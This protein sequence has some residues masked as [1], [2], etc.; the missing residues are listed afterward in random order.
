M[1][2]RAPW[3]F[4]TALALAGLMCLDTALPL[5]RAASAPR[6]QQPAAPAQQGARVERV[7]I[8]GNRRLRDEDVLYHIQ[9]RAGDPFS[10]E[11]VQRDLITLLNLP[12]FDKTETRVSTETGPLG[13]VI[14]IFTV[15]ELP[16]VRDVDFKGLKSV[17]E[18]DVLKAFR[19]QRVGVSKE[20]SLD[21]VKVN[22]ARRVIKELLAQSGHPN[23]VVNADVEEVSQTSVA[24]TFDINEG[25]RVRVVDIDFE[26]NKVFSDGELRGAMKYVKEAGLI[27]R[28]KGQDILHLEKLDADLRY[29]VRNYMAS[30][31]YLEA[32]TGEP[33]VEGVGERRTGFPVLPLPIISS[34]DEG[35]RVTVPVTEGRLYRLGQIKIEGNSIY[36]EDVIRQVIGLTPGEIANGQRIIKALSE[37]L[38]K[39]YGRS[40]FIQYEYDVSPEFKPNPQ[41]P[42]EGL[43]DFT[44]TITE[45]KQFSLRRLEFLGNT[46]TR[47][48]VL[49]REVAVNEGDIYDEALWDFS[50]LKLNQLGFFDPIDKEK[51]AEF[52]TDEE[53][54]EVDINLRVNERGRNQIAFNGGVSGIGGSFFGLDYSTNNLLGRGESL[55]FQFA[56]GNR[57]KSFLFSFTEPYIRD[58]PITVGFSLFTESRK[59]FGE[60]TLLSQNQEAIGGAFSVLDFLT[61][62][63]ENLFT[64]NTTGGSLFASAPLWEFYKPRSRR[65]IQISRASRVGLSYQLSRSSIEEPAVNLSGDQTQI[66][67]V[68]FSQ[69]NIMTSRVTPSFVFDSRDGSIDP[70]R[71]RQVALQFAFAGL[72][73]DVRTY[74]PTMTYMHFVP[75]RRKRSRTPEVFGYRLVAG[76]VGSFGITSNVETAQNTSLSFINGVPVY[77]RFFLGDEFSIRGY[78]VRSISPIV[79]LDVY[80]SSQNVK[81]STTPNN[82]VVDVTTVSDALRAQLVNLGTFTG[83]SG[84]NS[85]RLT[86]DFRF[87]GGD[88]QLLGNFEYRIPIFGPVQF[89]LFADI[90]SSFNLRTHAD[91]TFSTNFLPDQPFLP[92]IGAGSLTTLA[93]LR[94]PQL[95]VSPLGGLVVTGDRPVT[96][97]VL[98]DLTRLGPID[99]A[100]GLPFGLQAV[101]LRGEAQTNTVARFSESLFSKIGD[102]RSSLGGELRIQLP[103]VNVPFRFIYAWNPN[104]KDFLQEKKT[105]F[106][107]SIGRTF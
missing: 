104:A 18:S 79:P 74:Q 40:G 60:G 65:L 7:D 78:N 90:G 97:E 81:L 44:V 23:A 13:G 87:L 16:I 73:G 15:R 42:D 107:F 71:G 99:P 86:R 75:L 102:Y 32:R 45:G 100:T 67:P 46:F 80:V 52:R 89:A 101:F 50:V 6:R 61:V 51:D 11:Q 49:R 12:F 62:G 43:A 64:Q 34:V 14:V 22:N 47:D 58:R 33:R 85:L 98:T 84:A 35:L 5:A 2:I 91:Q 24:V 93:L 48:N 57:Q 88:T 95:A 94:N 9:T 1:R 96:K 53:R 31:G 8:E 20:T 105:A 4:V 83:P 37:D 39:L 103:V 38:K 92:S 70:T 25:D 3:I 63:E 36:S 30:K 69:P 72:G 76:H 28:F 82:P 27:S 54:G 56:F 21:P 17:P 59:F 77:E 19:E 26:G 106:R 10:A 29:N 41:K 66:I 55:S 68:V